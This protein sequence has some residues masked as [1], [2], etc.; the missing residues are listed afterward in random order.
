MSR[1]CYGFYRVHSRLSSTRT[2]AAEVVTIVCAHSCSVPGDVEV[3]NKISSVYSL[4][5]T[6][7][8]SL[9]KPWDFVWVVCDVWCV[10]RCDMMCNVWVVC[11][12]SLSGVRAGAR[13]SG[14]VG[15]SK[16]I[17]ERLYVSLS[18]RVCVRERERERERDRERE[19]VVCVCV[20]E[21]LSCV[22]A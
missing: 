12:D 17:D 21:R 15:E 22:C 1:R 8:I 20:R 11:N 5:N 19:T 14:R 18:F 16:P 3:R 4:K 6:A 10:M 13:K 9:L 2:T 7:Y